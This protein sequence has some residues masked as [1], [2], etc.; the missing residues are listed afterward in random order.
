MTM[1]T[2]QVFT[3]P[4]T[5]LL[6]KPLVVLIDVWTTTASHPL[7]RRPLTLIECVTL[8]P[9]EMSSDDGSALDDR[10]STPDREYNNIPTHR[11]RDSSR[12][13]SGKRGGADQRRPPQ[14]LPTQAKA[15]QHQQQQAMPSDTSSAGSPTHSLM[16][17]QQRG[18]SHK[19]NYDQTDI[20]DFQMRSRKY[21][22]RPRLSLIPI[23]QWRVRILIGLQRNLLMKA[24]W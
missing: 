18:T 15:Q 8:P 11:E 9:A 3:L 1:T 6:N 7:I 22:R 16:H 19:Y 20:S 21:Q 13:H 17:N 5:T 12:E 24:F 23:D 10:I 2:I 14:N 4:T